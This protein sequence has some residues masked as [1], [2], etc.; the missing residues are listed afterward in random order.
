DGAILRTTPH[1]PNMVKR[2]TE[3]ND[4]IATYAPIG[5]FEAGNA[6]TRSRNA[7]R[8]ACIAAKRAQTHTGRYSRR[9]ATAGATRDAR[10]IPRIAR[11]RG[12]GTVR[13]F[14]GVGLANQ[15]S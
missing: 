6:T 14:M 13:K 4:A 5:R 3:R 12:I 8:A 15:D 7:D 9:R 1:W 11:R 2:P 10:C